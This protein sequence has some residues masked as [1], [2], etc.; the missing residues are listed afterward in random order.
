MEENQNIEAPEP[1]YKIYYKECSQEKCVF[2]VK[3]E[4]KKYHYFT[5]SPIIS[6][7]NI[8]ILNLKEE[9][10]LKITDFD[11]FQWEVPENLTFREK[12][13]KSKKKQFKLKN[14][15]TV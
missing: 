11:K 2:L 8:S 13:R 4:Y 3:S 12:S 15:I 14:K 7:L 9:F 1:N 5:N 10:N 6:N